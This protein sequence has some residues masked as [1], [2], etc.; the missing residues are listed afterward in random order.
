MIWGESKADS[1]VWMKEECRENFNSKLK[2]KHEYGHDGMCSRMFYNMLLNEKILKKSA[3]TFHNKQP[4]G[5]IVL[6]LFLC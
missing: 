4:A 5:D 6:W 1:K 3:T 2:L